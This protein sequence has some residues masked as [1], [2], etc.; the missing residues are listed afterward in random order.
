MA[1]IG[2]A[3][4]NQV[5]YACVLNEFKHANGRNGMGAVMGSKR[6]KAIAVRGNGRT[7]PR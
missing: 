6:L 3:G 2:K 5:R 1:L 7:L 4:E